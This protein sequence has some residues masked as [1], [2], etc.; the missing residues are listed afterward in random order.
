M[1]K[2]YLAVVS[3]ILSVSHFSVANAQDADAKSNSSKEAKVKKERHPLSRKL[4]LSF[5]GVNTRVPEKSVLYVPAHHKAK[6]LASP[7]GKYLSWDKFFK[8]NAGWIHIYEVKIAHAKGTEY[9]DPKVID[10]YRSMG[11]VI[12][13]VFKGNPITVSDK[14]TNPPSDGDK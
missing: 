2:K 12:I 13:A 7:N 14:T 5:N 11:K 4:L 6:I 10:A 9:F 3:I 1:L 8:K